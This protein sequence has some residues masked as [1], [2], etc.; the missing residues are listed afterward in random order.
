MK[1]YD[2]III[3]GGPNGLTCAAYLA[4]AGAKVLLL[5][6]RFEL[7]GGLYTEDFGGPFRHDIHATYM[8]VGELMPPYRDFNLVNDVH[9]IRPEVQDAFVFKDGKALVFYTDPNKSAESIA[10]FSKKDSETFIKMYKEFKDLYHEIIIPQTYVPPTPILELAEY[11]GKTDLGKKLLDI[12]ELTPRSIIEEYYK[13]E[14]P[15]VKAALLYLGVIWGIHPN[16]G[17]VGYMVPLYTYGM[18]NAAI[19]KGGSHVLSSALNRQIIKNGGTIYEW[20][21]VKEI[22]VEDGEA[23]GVKLADGREFRA[24]AVVSTLNPYQTFIELIPKEK[25]PE[26]L[27][28]SAE[29]WMWEEWSL[30]VVNL[31][32]KGQPP[33]YKASDYN[34]DVDKALLVIM[35]YESVD[36]IINHIKEMEENKLPSPAGHLTCHTLFDPIRASSG[37]FG[38]LHT[39]RWECW[40]PYEVK[41]KHWDDIKHEYYKEIMRSLEDYIVNLKE[42]KI[43]FKHVWSPL[44]IERRLVTMKRGSIKHGAYV[45]LQMGIFRPNEACS[46]YRTPIKGLYVGGASV[47]PGGMITLGPGYNSAKVI[48]EDLGLKVWWTSPEYVNE[49][50]KKGYIKL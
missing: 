23:R 48:A 12:S 25:V 22:I 38:P 10:R 18:M 33:K 20:S 46:R 31:G 8:M 9:F 35:G 44:D 13:F 47:Y 30:F 43:L 27:R 19:I 14:D 1:E 17:G 16:A 42:I 50:I 41:G 49:A 21:E 36:D 40:A 24:K 34:P 2:V 7:G 45:S 32:I 26:D 15:R 39:L 28:K 3:G 37:P 6:K 11:L 4:K 5:E 29:K